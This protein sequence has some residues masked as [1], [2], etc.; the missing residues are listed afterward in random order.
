MFAESK[1]CLRMSGYIARKECARAQ[2][3]IFFQSYSYM[4]T[5][6]KIRIK[7]HD[8]KLSSKGANKIQTEVFQVQPITSTCSMRG[9]KNSN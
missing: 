9:K 3:E 1:F 5:K 7:T 8:Q 6:T 2:S 4:V